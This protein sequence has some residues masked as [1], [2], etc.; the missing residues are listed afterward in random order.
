MANGDLL[1]LRQRE[2]L[3]LNCKGDPNGNYAHFSLGDDYPDTRGVYM[4]NESTLNYTWYIEPSRNE[5]VTVHGFHNENNVVLL[6]L[7]IQLH[8]LDSYI[9]RATTKPSTPLEHTTTADRDSNGSNTKMIIGNQQST[10]G[11]PTESVTEVFT[12]VNIEYALY[13]TTTLTALLFTLVVV[14]LIAVTVMAKMLCHRKSKE[15]SPE[16]S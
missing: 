8:D 15:L 4:K 12:A 14:L 1:N 2:T 9:D 7:K 6:Q 10:D 13:V 16:D 11:Y 3:I 5:D